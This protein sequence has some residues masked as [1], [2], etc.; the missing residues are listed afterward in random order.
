[1]S[2][3]FAN[4]NISPHTVEFIKSLG[5]D[6]KSVR[7]VGLKGATDEEII[8]FAIKEGR[9]IITFDMDYAVAY[10]RVFAAKVGIIVIRLRSQWHEN[11][12]REIDRFLRAR[13]FEKEELKT[14]LFILREG[15]YKVYKT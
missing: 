9:I 4:E 10:Y 13:L 5:F 12:N 6:I 7:E 8:E 14:A 3:F 11:V 15:R 2:R 1:M